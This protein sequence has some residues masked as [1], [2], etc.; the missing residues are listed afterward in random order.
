MDFLIM[1]WSVINSIFLL[2]LVLP[3]RKKSFRDSN[4]M[5]KLSIWRMKDFSE[6]I[7]DFFSQ[8]IWIA[9]LGIFIY[10]IVAYLVSDQT[11][12]ILFNWYEKIFIV[13][14][15]PMFYNWSKEKQV[16]IKNI[17]SVCLLL[18]VILF[19]G[20]GYIIDTEN[21][22]EISKHRDII[23]ILLTIGLSLFLITLYKGMSEKN[24]NGT[25]KLPQ[26]G[27]RK[28][29]FYRIPGLD[30]N[31][32]PVE[33]IKYCEKYFDIYHRRYEKIREIE[34]IEYVKL[35]GIHRRYWY[36]KTAKYMKIF[37]AISGVFVIGGFI[38]GAEKDAFFLSG[39]IMLF[40]CLIKV[41][42]HVD[43][44]CLYKI[45][46]RYFY[47]EWGYCLKSNGKLHFVGTVQLVEK[48]KYHKYIH[49]FLD[50]VALCRAVAVNDKMLGKNN[51]CILSKNLGELF[52]YYTNFSETKSWGLIIPL[53]SVALFEFD[54]THKINKD[55]KLMLAKSL[56]DDKKND[57]IIFIQSLWADVNRKKLEDGVLEFIE[58]FKE[59]VCT[60]DDEQERK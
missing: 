43:Q 51:I 5:R 49:A 20:V 44:E 29:L 52:T 32:K 56:K 11:V 26:E 37:L 54:V 9:V 55:V 35:A 27:I 47:D 8:V 42:K 13:A 12:H 58:A 17:W 28:D 4:K 30:I 41:Y 25:R 10:I 1:I 53:W 22:S 39:L 33:L 2:I 3:I 40:A 18:T 7:L 38:Q 24:Q 45:G 16:N 48:S 50:I 19:S 15:F 14:L 21:L 59:E 36:A 34:T 31:V 60:K 23:N 6:K 57:I 46:I